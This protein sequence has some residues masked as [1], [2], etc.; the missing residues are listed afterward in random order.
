M[1]ASSFQFGNT[2]IRDDLAVALESSWGALSGPGAWLDGKQRSAVVDEVRGA[3]DCAL[4][5]RRKEALSPYVIQSE[6][7]QQRKLPASW[8][9]VIHKVVTD[10]GR[11]T[12]AW[13]D[14]VIG[15]DLLEDE[16]IELLGVS[17]AVCGI[18]AFCRGVG[19]DAPASLPANPGEPTRVRPAGARPGPGWAW[20]IAP[21]DAGPELGNFYDNGP[22]YIRRAL[23]L[24]PAE[25][26]RFWMMMDA[27]YLPDPGVEGLG[28]FQRGISRAQIEF[29]AARVSALLGCYY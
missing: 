2:P 3:W 22:Y 16:F 4:C 21:E 7:D 14:S 20:T 17:T 23:T 13:Y 5:R 18:D 12:H 24:V 11:I 9:E 25:L 19:I 28:K 6:H 27:M 15:D 26:H 8:V 29:L 10:N 1:T